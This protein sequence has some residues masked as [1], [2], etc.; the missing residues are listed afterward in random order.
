MKFARSRIASSILLAW[1]AL[2][3]GQTHEHDPAPVAQATAA[4]PATAAPVAASPVAEKPK[5]HWEDD[6][7]IPAERFTD[8]KRAFQ[9]LEQAM[10]EQYYAAGLTEDDMYRAAA[11]GMLERVDP[12]M[13]KWNK[14]LS[15]S[16]LA[17]MRTDMKGEMVGVGVNIKF[18]SDTGWTDVLGVIPGSPAE[19]AG[20]MVGDKIVS[21]NGKVYK[22]MTF[23]DV[24][25]DIRGKAGETVTLTILRGD[26]LVPF[27]IKREVIAYDAVSSMI[28]GDGIGYVL[29]HAFTEKTVAMLRAGLEDLGKKGAKAVVL[30]VRHNQG[31][32]FDEAVATASLFVPEGT[33]IVKLR[34]RGDKEE[35]FASK[36]APAAATLPI[37]IL[38]DNDTASGAELVTGALQEAR[39]AA[40]I[41]SRTH[42]KWSVQKIQELGNGYAAK[43]TTAVFVTP[44][45][46]SY[47]GV[48]LLPD[49]EVG[50]DETQC[51]KAQ[52]VTDPEKRLAADPQLRTAVAILRAKL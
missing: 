41:G 40:V 43:F 39:H 51:A 50:M 38:V 7:A 23:R 4:A 14:L 42:G 11:R 8:G 24:V 15:P 10:L 28:V 2:G 47:D 49:V 32:L 9:T 25:G 20:V 31:G 34:K 21:V 30:D 37:A 45:G 29:V 17:F 44:S 5:S 36:G 48:G 46:K 35:T 18:D 26:K 33:P 16:E 22:G 1:L 3:C 19:K 27:P 52:L 13:K 6:D 12:K